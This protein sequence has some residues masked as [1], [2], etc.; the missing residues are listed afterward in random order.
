VKGS[1]GLD[2][3]L[4]KVVFGGTGSSGCAMIIVGLQPAEAPGGC[5]AG[6]EDFGRGLRWS[7]DADAGNEP[8]SLGAFPPSRAR[9]REAAGSGRCPA[10]DRGGGAA[11]SVG[12]DGMR[13]GALGLAPEGHPEDGRGFDHASVHAYTSF[14]SEVRSLP[15]LVS[16]NWHRGSG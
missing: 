12:C 5:C 14:D 8:R 7:L 13:F 15:T 11:T 1:A 4:L 2:V 10:Q 3:R 6:G 16:T 9:F